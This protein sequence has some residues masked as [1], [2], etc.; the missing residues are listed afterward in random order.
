M[1]F[2]YFFLILNFLGAVFLSFHVGD[3]LKHFLL[4]DFLVTGIQILILLLIMFLFKVGVIPLEYLPPV[5]S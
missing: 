4:L 1:L 2:K 3:S 5:A